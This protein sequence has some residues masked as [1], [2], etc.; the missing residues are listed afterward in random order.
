MVFVIIPG[1]GAALTPRDFYR[2]LQRP[3]GLGI[4][5]NSQFGYMPVAGF[6]LASA[7]QLP[8]PIIIGLFILS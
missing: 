4:V 8:S 6:A 5:L 1:P 3:Y 2:A 7:M